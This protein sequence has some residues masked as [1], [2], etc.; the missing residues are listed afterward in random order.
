M[1]FNAHEIKW[2][3][4]IWVSKIV[5]TLKYKNS[6]E[7]LF[8]GEVVHAFKAILDVDF[9][10]IAEHPFKHLYNKWKKSIN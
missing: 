9:E 1:K 2:F 5:I 6:R 10:A 3:H 8:Y 7:H 4:S